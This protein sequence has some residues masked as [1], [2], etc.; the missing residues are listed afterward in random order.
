MKTAI[1]I[2]DAISVIQVDHVDGGVCLTVDCFG[3]H[4]KYKSLPQAVMFMDKVYGKTGWNS[5]R[6]VAYY[7]DDQPVAFPWKG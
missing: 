7:R 4:D 2:Q 3:G 5:D 6:G 1:P